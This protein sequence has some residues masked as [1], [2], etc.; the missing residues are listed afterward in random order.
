MSGASPFH[1]GERRVQA[2]LGFEDI[3]AWA[4]QVVR[5][6]MPEQHRAFF[7]AQPF[8]VAAAR[9]DRGRPWA[10]LL[11][12]R[13]G[14]VASP[15]PDALR[16]HAR[17]ARGD[18]L[19]GALQPGRD[20]GL[21]GI[22]F[23]TRRRNRAN[24]RIV[25][26]ADGA[27]AVAIDQSFGNCPQHIPERRW[28]WAPARPEPA[29]RSGRLN[30]RQRAWITAADSFFVATGF[31]GT[32]DSP[33]FGMDAS[34]RGGEPGFLE[35]LDDRRLRFPDFA[36]NRHFNTIGNLELDPRIGLALLELATGSLLQL[37][38]RARID[39]HP[40]AATPEAEREVTIE[41][42]EVVELPGALPLRWDEASGS[43]RTLRL[44]E[45]TRESADI[46]SFR[47]GA[48]D[49][50]PLPPFEAGQHLPLELPV[51]GR[52]APLSRSYSISSGP[53]APGYRIS[54]KR[55]PGGRASRWLHDVLEPGGV[56]TAHAPSGDFV[57]PE[58]ERPVALVSAGV[59]V[60]PMLSMLSALVGRPTGRPVHFV[61]GARDG[62]DHAFGDEVRTLAARDPN[63]RVHVAYSR[64][65]PHD[66]RGRAHQS[67]GRIGA[68]RLLRLVGSRD[69]E[70]LLCG[71]PAFLAALLEGL[72]AAGVAPSRLHHESFGPV[73][74]VSPKG[75]TSAS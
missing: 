18:A 36:G 46:V 8:L 4:R 31:R 61:H 14:F 59:G 6:E 16:I 32:G 58:G 12:N 15:R 40:S 52:A 43:A 33:T 10:T 48:R 68:E 20:L 65:R 38:G 34:H 37:T 55:E 69:A 22:E 53:D 17:P 23:A 2:R 25:A 62:R 35:A 21:L 27:L 7:A 26:F 75:R 49:G 64:P 1:D 42:E 39:W 57:L 28:R 19:E 13:P 3:D 73:Y 41:I 60:T 47:F 54:V 9:D 45:K 44:L 11:A 72:R 30:G 63:V 50:E 67:R 29:R 66:V 51:T 56:V 71:P 24:G 5:P 70:F 74:Q